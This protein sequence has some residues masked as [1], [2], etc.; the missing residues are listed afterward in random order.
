MCFCSVNNYPY[1]NEC[2]DLWEA[3]KASDLTAE[4]FDQVF[5]YS[6]DKDVALMN[7]TDDK[8]RQFKYAV[9]YTAAFL[10]FL[11]IIGI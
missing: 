8:D 2:K 3:L 11:F 6:H 1:C 4:E 10:L 5:R 7:N 9:L